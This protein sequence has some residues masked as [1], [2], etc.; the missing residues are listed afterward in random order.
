[1][2]PCFRTILRVAM[3]LFVSRGIS[4]LKSPFFHGWFRP[5]FHEGLS[6]FLFAPPALLF[7]LFP[8]S[9]EAASRF[10]SRTPIPKANGNCP[11]HDMCLAGSNREL[12]DVC[13]IPN[14]IAPPLQALNPIS[15]FSSSLISSMNLT[16]LAL[17]L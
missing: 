3:T 10:P 2:E 6:T 14:R 8:C 17:R 9:Q 4:C 16:G 11:H 1:M 12:Q 15:F 13:V 7:R 5:S